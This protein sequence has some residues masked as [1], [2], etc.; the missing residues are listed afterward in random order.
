MFDKWE[1]ELIRCIFYEHERIFLRNTNLS[2]LI[3]RGS[4]GFISAMVEM[5][6]IKVEKVEP[7]KKTTM[8]YIYPE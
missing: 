5:P 1:S 4:L 7:V 6:F 3:L 8:P 2:M